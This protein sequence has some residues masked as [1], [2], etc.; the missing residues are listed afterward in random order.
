V[1]RVMSGLNESKKALNGSTILAIGLS[2]KKNTGDPRESPAMRVT[3]LLA[4]QGA[5]L[6][7]VDPFVE[8]HLLP[9]HLTLVDLTE[10]EVAQADAIVILTDHDDLD[11]DL[12]ENARGF[13]LD[14]RR[15]LD[16]RRDSL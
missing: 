8:S 5:T 12:I 6:R 7:A 16:G 10:E 1:Q 11:Y 9:G 4:E 13:V 15:R 3:E 14:T 2:Y